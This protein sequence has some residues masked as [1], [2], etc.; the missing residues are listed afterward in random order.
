MARR[1]KRRGG[2][3]LSLPLLVILSLSPLLGACDQ[4][5]EDSSAEPAGEN[6]EPAP[7]QA[8][9]AE[10]PASPG[11]VQ[12]GVFFA[13]DLEGFTL[14]NEYDDDGDGDGVNETHVRRYVDDAGNSAFS[15]TTNDIAW[16]WSLDTQGDDDSDIHKNYVVRDSNCDGVIDERYSLDAEFHVPD[17]V[18]PGGAAE[19]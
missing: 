9:V 1:S 18:R 13:P 10:A 11:A 4:Q 16:A 6:A 17:C 19:N 15:M 3:G 5:P 12:K 8:A 2:S 14:E 7:A